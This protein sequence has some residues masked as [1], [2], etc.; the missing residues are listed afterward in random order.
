MTDLLEAHSLLCLPC[1]ACGSY[2]P[3]LQRFHGKRV[4]YFTVELAQVL[5]LSLVLV[6]P[7]LVVNTMA[8]WPFWVNSNFQ[9]CATTFVSLVYRCEWVYDVVDENRDTM[10]KEGGGILSKKD[11]ET[12]H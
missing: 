12:G 5:C 7:F 1:K 3:L 11:G 9:L 8:G 10:R 2:S 4:T 6:H